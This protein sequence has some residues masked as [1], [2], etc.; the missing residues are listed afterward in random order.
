[1]N[2]I[3]ASPL[4]VWTTLIGWSWYNLLWDILSGTG[5]VFLPFLGMLL[6]VWRESFVDGGDQG[7]AS[8]GVRALEM[9]VYSALLVILIAALPNPLTPVSP[10]GVQY[11]SAATRVTPSAT[12]SG[13]SAD[14]LGSAFTSMSGTSANVPPWWYLV[15]R[16][17]AGI[18]QAFMTGIDQ[19]SPLVGMRQLQEQAKLIGISDAGLR[20]EAL[21]FYNECYVPARTKFLAAP[22]SA[23]AT[24][25]MA[26]HGNNDDTEW[27]GSRAFRDDPALYGALYAAAPVAGWPYSAADASAAD[28]AGEPNPPAY[29]RPDC[30]AWWEDA[31]Y[32]LRAKLIGEANK[33]AALGTQRFGDKMRMAFSALSLD[34]DHFADVTARTIL[35]ND[36]PLTSAAGAG[37]GRQAAEGGRNTVNTLSATIA[38]VINWLTMGV[39]IPGLQML[40]PLLLMGIYT[41]LPLYLVLA[42]YSL[43]ALVIGALGIFTV[44]FWTALWH[45][46]N[47]LDEKLIAALYPDQDGV[48]GLFVTA[49]KWSV[50]GGI[51]DG[52]LAKRMILDITLLSLYVALP[53]LWTGMMAWASIKLRTLGEF[54]GSVLT[55]LKP[56]GARQARVN[57][58]WSEASGLCLGEK[59]R[60]ASETANPSSRPSQSPCIGATSLAGGPSARYPR[61]ASI[62]SRPNQHQKHLGHVPGDQKHRPDQASRRNAGLFPS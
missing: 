61:W 8:R 44:K 39:I 28:V 62:G 4:E 45:A 42:R 33:M 14:T 49:T 2:L 24:A 9:E 52:A 51:S 11:N 32:G 25:A 6:D 7:A 54:K 5:I 55:S 36:G 27:L 41:L 17:S 48:I 57:V 40:Q 58:L 12:T 34:M 15:M 20:S 43:E 47:W 37:F 23:A 59:V 60:P 29:A 53:A 3:V 46:V 30:K 10:A 13:T 50:F 22:P 56:A 19:G 1:M 31:A 35:N 38:Y 16:V 26:A 21:R 18:D